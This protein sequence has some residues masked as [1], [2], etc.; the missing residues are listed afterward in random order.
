MVPLSGV[1]SRTLSFGYE[2]QSTGNELGCQGGTSPRGGEGIGTRILDSGVS[3]GVF[4]QKSQI[5]TPE[6][7]NHSRYAILPY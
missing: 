1:G 7:F 6:L 5:L 3:K 2:R 4:T